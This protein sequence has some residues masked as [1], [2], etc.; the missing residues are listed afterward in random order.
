[1]LNLKFLQKQ[2]GVLI[3]RIEDSTISGKIAKEVFEKMWASSKDTDDI[4]SEQGLQQVTDLSEIEKMVE[5]VIKK[6]PDQLEK[7]PFRER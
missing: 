4:I 1:M 3:R 5:E 2:L 7:L 6:N